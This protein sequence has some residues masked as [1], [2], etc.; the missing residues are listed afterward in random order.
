MP[1][2]TGWMAAVAVA[3]IAAVTILAATGNQ[4]Q[5]VLGV[6][7]GLAALGGIDKLQKVEKANNG[8]VTKLAASS[9]QDGYRAGRADAI[10]GQ[11][12]PA[13]PVAVKAPHLLRQPPR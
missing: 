8:T 2:I 10:T 4:P 13:N 5:A 11:P 7:G 12:D 9:F 3:A 1:N 6:L